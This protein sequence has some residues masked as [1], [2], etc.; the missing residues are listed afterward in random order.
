MKIGDLNSIN[1]LIR[2][3]TGAERRAPAG[4]P[5]SFRETLTGLTQANAM[6]KLAQMSEELARQGAILGRRC[7]ILELK[8]YK[9]RLGEYLHEAVRFMY[10]F[11]KQST[12]DARG[13]HKMYAIIK[14]I[15]SKLEEM[16][17]ELLKSEASNLTVMAAI[18][19]IRGMLVDLM[20]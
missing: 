7:D 5:S 14:R 4:Q 1:Q 13:R 17:E 11:K 19:E 6:D 16:T 12:L 20:L 15:N 10:E 3:G 9:E 2:S 18:D 8:R